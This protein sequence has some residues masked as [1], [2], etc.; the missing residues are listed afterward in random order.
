VFVNQEDERIA[1]AVNRLQLAAVQLHGEESPEQVERL[2]KNLPMD[3]AVWKAVP[4][5][6]DIPTVASTGAD[7]LLVDSQAVGQRGGTGRRFDWS[8]IEKHPERSEL[9]LAGGLN[10][11]NAAEADRLMTWALDVNSGVEASPGN[12]DKKLLEEFFGKLRA[13]SK[14]RH[15]KQR[16]GK[17]S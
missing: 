16:D 10:P 17:G 14:A 15:S 6:G 3:C 5:A 13:P 9:V 12:K 2:R 4:G 1:E 8:L 11:D 7:R